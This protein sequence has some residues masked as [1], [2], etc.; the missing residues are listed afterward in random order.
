MESIPLLSNSRGKD[1]DDEL[2]FELIED[3]E[4]PTTSVPSAIFNLSN[5]IVGAG[6]LSLPFAFKNTGVIVGPAILVGVFLLVVLS[7]RMLISAAKLC[8]AARSYT[9]IAFYCFGKRGV[10]ATQLSL[11]VSCYGACTGYLV[12]VGD[13]LSPLIG[14]WMGG[15]P[16]DFCSTYAHRHFSISLALLVVCPLSLARHVDS[17]RYASYLAIVMV[18]YL[19]VIVVVRSRESLVQGTGERVSF[20]NIS[21]AIFRAVPIVTLAY[22]CQMNL[23]SLLATLENPTRKRVRFV[24]TSALAICMSVYV[25]VGLFGYLTFF[26]D[27]QGN[28]LLNYDVDDV[29]IM[30]GRLGVAVVVL[31]SFPL[32]MHPCLDAL[33]QMVF[34]DKPFT[35]TRRFILMIA[36]V[37]S[38]YAIAMLVSDVS[39][40]LGI[41]G[42]T[43]STSISFILP[44]LFVLKLSPGK[45]Y[46]LRQNWVP[47]ALL[48]LGLMFMILSTVVTFID[49]FTENEDDLDLSDVC[50]RTALQ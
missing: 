40:V 24:F 15:S 2:E 13:M 16:A 26:E 41:A 8:D 39:L 17:L 11:I 32:L 43:G 19:V 20:A 5:T 4:T 25:L 34:P 18:I 22:T 9:A 10:L 21:E 29:Y 27:T 31:C 42:A 45:W 37:G 50:N 1:A 36:A 44:P 48:V 6:I 49:A 38:A 14:Q 33:Q 28:V 12:I 46:N 7:C 30:V 47:L 3:D 35:Y 23:F